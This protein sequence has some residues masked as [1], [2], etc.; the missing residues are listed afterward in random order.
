MNRKHTYKALLSLQEPLVRFDAQRGAL[1]QLPVMIELIKRAY[2]NSLVGGKH[3]LKQS[4]AAVTY[5]QV[6][7]AVAS[8]YTKQLKAHMPTRAA[9]ALMYR[10]AQWWVSMATESWRHIGGVLNHR[11]WGWPDLK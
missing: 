1:V 4:S 8:K 11:N 5:A 10:Q 2:Y 3:A 6:R 7:D 9:L